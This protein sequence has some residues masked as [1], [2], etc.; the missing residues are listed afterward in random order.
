M[1][2]SFVSKIENLNHLFDLHPSERVE[3]LNESVKYLHY[4]QYTETILFYN[5]QFAAILSNS[6]SADLKS[7]LFFLENNSVR[8]ESEDVLNHMCGFLFKSLQNKKVYQDF[9]IK[10]YIDYVDKLFSAIGANLAEFQNKVF[11]QNLFNHCVSCFK[12]K[13][14]NEIRDQI[15]NKYGKPE[16]VETI[17]NSNF[18]EFIQDDS[19]L[20]KVDPDDLFSKFKINRVTN[21]FL[22]NTLRYFDK[23]NEN[24][25]S[26]LSNIVRYGGGKINAPIFLQFI[27]KNHL[28]ELEELFLQDYPDGF[29]KDLYL[30][31]YNILNYK[32]EFWVIQLSK[33]FKELVRYFYKNSSKKVVRL[34]SE[35]CFKNKTF[36][37]SYLYLGEIIGSLD[38]NK[39][40]EILL[41]IKENNIKIDLGQH[42][43]EREKEVV[44]F[45]IN[46]FPK[47]RIVKYLFANPDWNFARLSTF[48]I[49]TSKYLDK[50]SLKPRK[51]ENIQ[52]LLQRIDLEVDILKTNG[53]ILPINQDVESKNIDKFT[54]QQP[55][56]NLELINWGKELNNCLIHDAWSM[57]IYSHKKMILGLFFDGKVQF[58]IEVSN[59]EIKQIEG[60]NR[61][62]PNEQLL[63]V[64]SN[65][66]R[67]LGLIL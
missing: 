64:I 44:S 47:K 62:I 58:C 17:S 3:I 11:E 55:Q 36:D 16:L 26:W 65:S 29:V 67:D 42:L 43:S 30:Q 15:N 41:Y 40:Q 56:S 5:L 20:T 25:R 12:I 48:C 2:S 59:K 8:I 63:S 21:L 60:K 6:E 57:D 45:A 39:I 35:I 14:I 32:V 31:N 66:L 1:E 4:S 33:D 49:R 53:F 24:H 52:K 19:N 34:L 50:I 46:Y 51:D 7:I 9:S 10:E 54:I 61:I 27:S 37:F 38:I 28:P 22:E 13:N 18:F 23:N